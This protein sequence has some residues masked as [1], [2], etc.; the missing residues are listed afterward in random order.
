MAFLEEN[1]LVEGVQKGSDLCHDAD[2][3][4]IGAHGLEKKPKLAMLIL[5]KYNPLDF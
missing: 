5:R 3:M 4:L 1:E 2:L